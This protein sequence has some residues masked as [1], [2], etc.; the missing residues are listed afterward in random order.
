[1][2]PPSPDNPKVQK[3]SIAAGDQRK[4]LTLFSRGER[5]TTSGKRSP[6]SAG[7]GG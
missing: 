4:S 3:A 1:M 6:L 5:R 7:I 2:S